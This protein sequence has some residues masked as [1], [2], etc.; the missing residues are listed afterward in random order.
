MATYILRTFIGPGSGKS[1]EFNQYGRYVL[2]SAC[3][4]LTR[5]Y[6]YLAE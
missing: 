5:I 2:F 1:M 4:I 6:Y 3:E